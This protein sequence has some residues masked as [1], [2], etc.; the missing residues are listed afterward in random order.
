MNSE[1]RLGTEK[2]G[3]L[4]FSMGIP[5]LIAQLVNLLYNIVDRIYI[6]HIAQI[7]SLALTGVGLVFPITMFISAFSALVMGG[8]PIAAIALGKGD[9]SQ[10]KSILGNGVCILLIFSV[11]LGAVFFAIKKP[12]L[13]MFGASDTTYIYS[14][15][16]LSVYLIG[17]VFVMLS[18]GL[19]SYI[20]AQGN[21]KTAMISVVI[22]AVMNII[23]DPVFI[24]GFGWSVKG[25]ALATV[26]SQACS[27]L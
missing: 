27:A 21:S 20:T 24:F 4:M 6:G 1:E 7:G 14:D 10:A 15:S 12:F 3:R 5:T 17:T 22:G 26:I 19:N 16:Y 18:L 8:A 23:L 13:Y 9:K 11:V 25:A 2:I